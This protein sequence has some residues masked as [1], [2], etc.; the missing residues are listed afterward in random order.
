MEQR[1][2]ELEGAQEAL[3]QAESAVES[4]AWALFEE[5]RNTLAAEP[6]NDNV[7]KP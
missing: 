1:E 5:Y 6:R 3:C 7:H 2:R 4:E